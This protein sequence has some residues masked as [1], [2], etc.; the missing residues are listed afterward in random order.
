MGL[1]VRGC[2]DA[3]MGVDVGLKARELVWVGRREESCKD[4][5]AGGVPR[6]GGTG[7]WDR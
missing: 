7:G 6:Q 2:G 5:I 4:G 1:L 3:G